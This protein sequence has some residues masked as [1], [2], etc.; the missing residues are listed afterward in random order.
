M[1]MV[2]SAWLLQVRH[3]K[4][5]QSADKIWEGIYFL[6]HTH[7]ALFIQSFLL[8]CG[9]GAKIPLNILLLSWRFPGLGIGWGTG[10]CSVKL[11]GVWLG[12]FG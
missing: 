3:C 12:W 1:L 5:L 11:A 6:S 10:D 4:V 9:G 2:N 7:P 8:V